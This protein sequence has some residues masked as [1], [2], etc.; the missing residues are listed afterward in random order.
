MV[1]FEPQSK[2]NIILPFLSNTI[3]FPLRSLKISSSE[4]PGCEVILCSP[5]FECPLEIRLLLTGAAN[6]DVSLKI[7]TNVRIY[8]DW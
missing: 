3:Y 7:Y 8:S 4:M 2:F 6:P 5:M 1:I